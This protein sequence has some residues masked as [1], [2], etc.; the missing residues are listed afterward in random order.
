MCVGVQERVKGFI[1]KIKDTEE[2][3]KGPKLTL[4]KDSSKR[5]VHSALSADQVYVD[6]L[7]VKE[8]TETSEADGAKGKKNA[9]T[10]ASGKGGSAKN[11]KRRRK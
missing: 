6:A 9:R 11:T 1:K 5:M 4:D 8:K 2:L 10:Q 7:A 3:A